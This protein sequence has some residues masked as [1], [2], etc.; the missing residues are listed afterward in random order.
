MT[1]LVMM[2]RTRIGA[3]VI[4]DDKQKIHRRRN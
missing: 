3:S 4:A 1:R 2:W